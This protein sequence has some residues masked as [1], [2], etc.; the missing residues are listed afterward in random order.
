MTT[1]ATPTP[2]I[3]S[4]PASAGTVDR[5]GRLRW[6]GD[7]SIR[8]RVLALAAFMGLMTIVVT[9]TASLGARAVS[10]D[11]EHLNRA[12]A[13]QDSV[14]QARYDLLWASNW[15][16]I[17]AWKSRS[18]GGAS[19][20]AVGGDNLKNY[21]DGVD[22]FERLFEV[23]RSALGASAVKN[24]QTIQDQWKQLL[25]Y[26]DQIFALWREGKLDQGDKVSG[27][28]KWDIYYVIAS[29]LDKLSASAE[30]HVVQAQADIDHAQSR[31]RTAT[32]AVTAIALVLGAL[33]ALGLAS[34]IMTPVRRM[35]DGLRQV[36][37]GDLAVQV[38]VIY[39]DEVGEMAES[40]D[41]AL[42]SLRSLVG[43][44]AES[45]TTVASAAEEL[46]ATASSIE[47]SA[48]STSS[49]SQVVSG[50][51]DEVSRSVGAVATGAEEMGASIREIAENAHRAAQVASDA[52]HVAA[53]TT[54]TVAKL[55]ASSEE[56]GKIVKVITSIAE[57]TNL[58]ALNATI[59]AA[60][61]GDAGKGFAVVAGEVK[62]LAQETAR[63]TEEISVQIGTI[64]ND[65]AESVAAIN[66]I[67]EI[68]TSI[69]DYQT[70]IATAV[71][72]QTA[73]TNEMTQ[74]VGEAATGSSQIAE[75]ISGVA[76]SS[77]ATTDAVDQ[78]TAAIAELAGMAE[79]LRSQVSTFRY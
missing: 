63:A 79:S 64:Q 45:A 52:V 49:Q 18:D 26:N 55:G 68:V 20:A 10:N 21:Q 17:T 11:A 37:S 39:H 24:L 53:A 32:Y 28:P 70:T 73:T 33:I 66:R 69:N 57:Q 40:L 71:E 9:G 13:V 25:D 2:P 38:P 51:A 1:R 67:S 74:R 50:A 61:A 14:E 56:I 5:G 75:H 16:N 46:T 23:D 62:E 41:T 44:V 58:L 36:A 34:S 72:E 27:G 4:R 47:H 48:R 6:I 76:G 30:K 3:T 12:V 65:T 78:T 60:R 19:A 22:G 54:E 35:R 8:T 29:A 77:S 43:S 59:E 42:G 15:Q 31:T 7:R